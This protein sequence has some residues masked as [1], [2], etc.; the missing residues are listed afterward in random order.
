LPFKKNNLTGGIYPLKI[1]EYLAAGRAVV[2]TDFSEDVIGFSNSVYLS[3]DADSF[4]AAINTAINDYSAEK[5]KSR[6]SVAASNAWEKRV[7]HFWELAWQQ[8]NNQY[9]K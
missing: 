9:K 7:A 3:P 4:V 6:Q 5:V 2:T 8:Y 1:N